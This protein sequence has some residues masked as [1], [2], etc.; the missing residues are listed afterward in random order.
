MQMPPFIPDSA[1]FT[2]EQRGWLNGFL[3]GLYSTA[4]ASPVTEPPPSLKIAVLYASQSG[5]AESLA[6]K[7]TKDLKAKGHIASLISLEGYTPATLLAER[8]AIFIASTYGEGDAPDAVQPSPTLSVL[9]GTPATST[10]AN[11]ARTLITNSLHSAASVLLS[12]LTATSISTRP[13]PSGRPPSTPPSTKSPLPALLG[14][15]PLLPLLLLN[16][17]PT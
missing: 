5:T 9:S 1:P 4:S 2:P 14:P 6:R 10:S 3:A 16:P 12:A 8:Y 15:H 11:S 13:L 17:Q 7:V